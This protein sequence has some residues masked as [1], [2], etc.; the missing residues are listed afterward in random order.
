MPGRRNPED[1][2]HELLA[3]LDN[4]DNDRLAAFY[5]EPLVAQLLN[6][7]YRRWEENSRRGEPLDYAK[8][9][10]LEKLLAL[11]KR[12][13]RLQGWEARRRWLSRADV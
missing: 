3:I 6:T 10:E 11:A 2:K 5:S 13:A 12:I 9:S 4:F 1:L 7:L 8:S